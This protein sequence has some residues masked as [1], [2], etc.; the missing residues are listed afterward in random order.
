MSVK[1]GQAHSITG[2]AP[3]DIGPA[4]SERQHCALVT[5][6]FTTLARQYL[7]DAWSTYPYMPH[8]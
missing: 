4:P 7:C 5:L 2:H 3:E 6:P 8:G 1:T